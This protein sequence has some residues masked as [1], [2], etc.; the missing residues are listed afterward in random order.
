MFFCYYCSSLL[1]SGN[2]YHLYLN[3][4]KQTSVMRYKDGSTN[5]NSHTSLYE[6]H[7]NDQLMVTSDTTCS[8]CQVTW[9]LW[10]LGLAMKT[11]VSFMLGR[12]SSFG[13]SPDGLDFDSVV[14][15]E[16]NGWDSNTYTY[17]VQ[18]T[19]IYSLAMSTAC[20][21]GKENDY[22]L[23]INGQQKVLNYCDNVNHAGETVTTTRHLLISLSAGDMLKMSSVHYTHPSLFGGY[24]D[25]TLQTSFS[26]FLYSPFHGCPAAWSVERTTALPAFRSPLNP[27]DFDSVLV[28]LDGSWRSSN[29]AECIHEGTYVIFINSEHDAAAGELAVYQYMIFF[30]LLIKWENSIYSRMWLC[31]LDYSVEGW[32]TTG[33]PECD[34]QF[35]S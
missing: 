31:F 8:S 29:K 3:G 24:S 15:D 5:M 32:Y 20:L 16:G 2:N 4:N 23:Y 14:L 21:P 1:A 30:N 17:T 13:E 7:K 19:G 27:I 9:T 6:Y 34:R 28:N 25:A 22:Q 12:T 26:G 35:T 33:Q 18:V 10:A 11:H